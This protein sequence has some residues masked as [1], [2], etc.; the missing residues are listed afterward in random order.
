MANR[1]DSR[2]PSGI[3]FVIT[4]GD[5]PD[6]LAT[7]Q[8]RNLPAQ[9]ERLP[10]PIGLRWC[11]LAVVLAMLGVLAGG[12]LYAHRSRTITSTRVILMPG[13][14]TTNLTGCPAQAVC[15]VVEPPGGGTLFHP[16]VS[17]LPGA[18]LVGGESV[19]D[20]ASTRDYRSSLVMRTPDGVLVTLTSCYDP[21]GAAIPAWQSP[22]PAVGPADIALVVPGRRPGTAVA[23]TATVPAGVPVPATALLQLATDPNLQLAP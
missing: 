15:T 9:P 14:A 17:Y 22:L 11:L 23:V 3:D 8:N 19:Y 1:P 16:A 18:D 7:G 6:G 12:L 2:Q 13:Q 20:T 5:G 10:R 4:D 21:T